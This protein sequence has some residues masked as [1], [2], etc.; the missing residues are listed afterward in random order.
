[1]S[2]QNL[3]AAPAPPRNG[4]PWALE[5]LPPF[6]PVAMRLVQL[7]YKDHVNIRDVAEFIAA[8]PVFAAR[9][10]QIA[11]SPLFALERQVRTISHAAVVIGLERV[12][13][14]ALTRALGDFT[15]PA[16]KSAAL[17]A[18]WQNSLAGAVL[19][20]LL[21]RPCNVDDGFAYT[22]GLLRDIG[23]LALLVQYPEA[24]ANLLAVS[25][26]SCFDLV[27]SER[28]LFDIDHCHAGEWIAARMPLPLEL[29]EAIAQHHDTNLDPPFRAVHLVRIADRMADAVGFSVQAAAVRPSFEEVLAEL[30]E[31]A[32]A[33]VNWTPEELAKLVTTRLA[34][35][36]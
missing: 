13:G 3:E 12:K 11:N 6:S 21:A 36:T 22:A 29:C 2:V 10:L 32:L 28:E 1:M 4:T 14:I 20:E 24:Y 18:C 26:E 33:Q 9:V 25:Q 7:L 34:A 23:R 16:L 35:W 5:H 30:P 15:A 31:Q 8:E 27:A 17:K 19:A